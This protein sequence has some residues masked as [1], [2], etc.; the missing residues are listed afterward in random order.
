LG[1]ADH[2]ATVEG[3]LQE[4]G[5]QGAS[6]VFDRRL[7]AGLADCAQEALRTG[8]V[9]L[10]TAGKVDE[11][12]LDKL[13]V[14]VQQLDRRRKGRR[15]TTSVAMVAAAGMGCCIFKQVAGSVRCFRWASKST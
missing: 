10:T 9:D 14:V 4:V 13:G 6:G 2:V 15:I 7:E 5:G 3:R 12:G 11:L 8:G 1:S